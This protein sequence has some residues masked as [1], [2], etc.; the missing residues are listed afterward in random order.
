MG[1]ELNGCITSSILIALAPPPLDSCFRI[2]LRGCTRPEE[3]G[4]GAPSGMKPSLYRSSALHNACLTFVSGPLTLVTSQHRHGTKIK[5]LVDM[6]QYTGNGFGQSLFHTCVLATV[7]YLNVRA[8]NTRTIFLGE[9]QI[10]ASFGLWL[11]R[12]GL[13]VNAFKH[14][15]NMKHSS[16]GSSSWPSQCL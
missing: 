6:A 1:E 11:T 12:A 16:E 3:I 4:S 2:L 10:F 15:S 5:I 8:G 13:T 7:L 14:A 9:A